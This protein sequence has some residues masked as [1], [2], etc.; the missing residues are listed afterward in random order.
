MTTNM[1]KE[2]EIFVPDIPLIAKAEGMAYV[3]GAGVSAGGLSAKFTPLA[4][5]ALG[6][7]HVEVVGFLGG[8]LPMMWAADRTSDILAP[9]LARRHGIIMRKM[10]PPKIDITRI[11]IF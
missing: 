9:D 3:T 7:T 4:L 2:P 8:L 1:K 6:F 11:K 10:L 5:G